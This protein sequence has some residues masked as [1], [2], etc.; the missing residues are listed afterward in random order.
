MQ[1]RLSVTIYVLITC[2]VAVALASWV[3]P[4]WPITV[5]QII[6]LICFSILLIAVDSFEIKGATGSRYAP[7]AAVDLA[8]WAIFGPAVAMLMEFTSVVV[9][10]MAIRRSSP[11]RAVFNAATLLIGVGT[12]G[13]VFHALPWSD[14]LSSPLFLIPA[15]ISQFVF[16]FLNMALTAGV[17][18]LSQGTSIRTIWRQLFGW[19]FLASSMNAPLAAFLIFSYEFAGLWSLPLFAFPLVMVWQTHKM[20]EQMKDAHKSTVAAL[21]TALEADEP[22]THGHSYRV[23][24]YAL[25]MGRRLGMSESEL[26]TL[27][28]GGLLHDIG[29][30][31]ITNDIVCKPAR[32]TKEEFDILA[33]HPAIGGEIVEQMSFLKNAA[34]LV[35]HH[36]ER[37]DGLGYPDA[38]KGD[39]ISLGS[40]ILNLADAIDA[41]TSNRPY[42]MALSLQQCLDEAKRFRGTQ[43]DTRVVDAFEAMI[44]DGS[45]RL[46]DQADGSALRIQ[47]ILR[48]AA[49]GLAPAIE[50]DVAA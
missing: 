42:R 8:V 20:F 46:I 35:R 29:K 31:A 7:F 36:H 6:P 39:E 16:S 13:V 18:G 47:Q 44:Q 1:N 49:G 40:H 30:I 41:M 3:L 9:G 33:S 45:F 43:F 11:V 25:Q 15:A 12:A 17:I 50:E 21:T 37:P 22:Y 23:A 32:L 38:L 2:T 10:D 19:H 14:D 26:E 24:N 48:E 28:Y 27:E 4:M 34:Q 5:G